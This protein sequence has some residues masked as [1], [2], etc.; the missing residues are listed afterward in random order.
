MSKKDSS[1]D[2]Q[3][4]TE[5]LAT[6]PD[7]VQIGASSD[8]SEETTATA[9]DDAVVVRE[10]TD[11]GDS[12]KPD[13]QPDKPAKPS[14]TPAASSARPEK[15]PVRGS[16]FGLFNFLLILLLAGAAGYYW[17]LQQQQEAAYQQQISDLQ[18][19]IATKAN[20]GQVNA[21]IAPVKSQVS[22]LEKRLAALNTEQQ[23]LR[24]SSEKLY[25]LFGRDKN[26]WQLAEVEYLMR[27]AQHKLV[28]QNDFEGAAITLQAASDKIGE[29]ADPGL[30]PV[31]VVISEEIAALKTRKRADLVGM[32]L[33]LGQ[34]ERQI[35]V[36]KP[37]FAPRVDDDRP[38]AT[39]PQEGDWMQRFNA[40]INSLVEV[41]YEPSTPTEVEAEVADV[42]ETL[43]DNLKLARW[44]VLERDARQ[45]QQLIDQSL[46]LFREFYNLDDAANHDFQKQLG[47][48]QKMQLS[49]E[50]PD[51]T[52]SLRELQRILAVRE[53]Q[54]DGTDQ[55][56]ASDAASENAQ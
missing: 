10:K 20:A 38:I 40:F 56:A 25:A 6:D 26:D 33:K 13:T 2:T 48:L 45:Y 22:E 7:P 15:P 53:T 14:K 21:G 41:R 44:A 47:S 36:L 50:L 3:T 32:A 28:L 37:G 35:R 39:L 18:S 4:S 30:I 1:S 17:W 54:P 11:S 55:S 46:R 9:T 19:Q 49:P 34:L 24:D 12:K 5:V 16:F 29:T 43:A 42:S 52:T 8:P 23:G 51:I 27:I 31:R